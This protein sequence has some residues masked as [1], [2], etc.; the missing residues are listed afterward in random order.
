MLHRPRTRHRPNRPLGAAGRT[1]RTSA[2]PTVVE[3]RYLSEEETH[4]DD[5]QPRQI[6]AVG[7]PARFERLPFTKYQRTLLAMV[8]TAFFFDSVDVTA[9]TFTLAPISQDLHLGATTSGFLASSTFAGMAIGAS[10]AGV[11]SDRFGRRPVFAYSM[12]FWGVASLLTAFAWDAPSLLIFRF[13]TGLGLGAELPVAQALVSEILPTKGRGRYASWLP[14]T[15]TLAFILSG[16]LSLVLVPTLGWRAVF[17]LIFVFSLFGFLIRRTVPESPRW[18]EARGR[19]DDAER[20]MTEFEA[21]V[22]REYGSELPEPEPEPAPAP[23][24]TATAGDRPI[25]ILLSG[26]YR[27][28]T[29]MAWGM[30]LLL[31]LAYYA[32]TAWLAKLLVQ[33]GLTVTSSIQF[34]LLMQ[35]WGIPG[36]LLAARLMERWGRRPILFLAIVLSAGS[37]FLYGSV[38]SSVAVI[39]AGSLLQF[40]FMMM[41]ASVYTYTP[42]LFPTAAR[43]T[44]SGT[45]STAGRI[46]AVA[47]PAL[48]PSLLAAWGYS[49]TFAVLAGIFLAAGLLVLAV[50]PETRGRVLEEVSN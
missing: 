46:G 4:V 20:A 30:W 6:S 45:A 2:L 11:I 13:L 40:S 23:T 39:A 19:H 24:K 27:S 28:R 37:A 50:G 31:Q 14:G 33:N 18:Y 7:L 49:A 16:S 47:G 22:R 12:L 3:S 17:V 21:N 15:I 10:V 42:E 32:I 36:F 48:L 8:A 9:L 44:G 29:L 1:R 38:T 35:V 34:V 25:R 5:T 41:W 26:P 43:A